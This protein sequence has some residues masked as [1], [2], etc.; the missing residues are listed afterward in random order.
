MPGVALPTWTDRFLVALDEHMKTVDAKIARAE[1]EGGEA[2]EP[3]L[4]YGTSPTDRH[5]NF[6]VE[7]YDAYRSAALAKR[8]NIPG[9]KAMGD[10]T[11]VFPKDTPGIDIER[12]QALNRGQMVEDLRATCFRIVFGL[13]TPADIDFISTCKNGPDELDKVRKRVDLIG[14]NK[15]AFEGCKKQGVVFCKVCDTAGYCS[16]GH[17][18]ED[19]AHNGMECDFA[20]HVVKNAHVKQWAGVLRGDAGT[21][22]SFHTKEKRLAEFRARKCAEDECLESGCTK[23]C[24]VCRQAY[25]CGPEHQTADWRARHKVECRIICAAQN[26]LSEE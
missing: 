18:G 7:E 16:G 24:A 9:L 2:L 13:T 8:A 1:K 3:Y 15:C 20:A 26:L 4:K 25:Y 19:D 11:I 21:N 6:C 17:L 23:V 12:Y 14:S 10:G 22:T 5:E